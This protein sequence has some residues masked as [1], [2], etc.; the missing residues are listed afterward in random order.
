MKEK[1]INNDLSDCLEDQLDSGVLGRV[2][3]ELFAEV[4][5]SVMFPNSLGIICMETKVSVD[6]FLGH[7]N[8]IVC[9]MSF[10]YIFMFCK[11][12]SEP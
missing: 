3:S 1:P 6:Y 8:G 10:I 11:S 2:G 7:S 12:V 4:P 5:H 9:L